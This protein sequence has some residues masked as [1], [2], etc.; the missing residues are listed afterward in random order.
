MKTLNA[1]LLA[2]VL[3]GCG[4]PAPH[5]AGTATAPGP[6]P[7]GPPTEPE[8]PPDPNAWKTVT[9]GAITAEVVSVEVRPVKTAERFTRTPRT[10]PESL[11]VRVR[12]SNTDDTFNAA[13]AVFTCTEASDDFGNTSKATRADAFEYLDEPNEYTDIT[14]GHPASRSFVF[15]R[16]IPKATQVAFT[17]TG[18]FDRAK[19]R[20]VEFPF[21]V[22][23]P[24]R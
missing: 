3:A 7:P 8:P 1:A 16:P 5:P 20:R 18:H 14:P 6:R 9:L 24:G 10:G 4:G 21:V 12:F 22:P 11:V 15:A 13:G 19:E 17:I 2:V 23:L